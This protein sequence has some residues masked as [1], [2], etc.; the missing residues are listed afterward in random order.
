[1]PKG[2]PFSV[3][4]RVLF[5]NGAFELE[6]VFEGVG[7]PKNTFLFYRDDD[8]SE[9]IVIQEHNPYQ[10]ELQYFVDCV[11]GEVDTELLDAQHAIESLQ[12]SIATQR[13]LREHQAI[14]LA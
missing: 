11:R 1:M 4:F 9:T 14:S 3:G 6:T 5:E 13:S 2:F 10:K 12:L 7:P 8:R